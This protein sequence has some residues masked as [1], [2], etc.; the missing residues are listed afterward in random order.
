MVFNVLYDSSSTHIHQKC[1]FFEI[2]L[3]PQ[4][5]KNLKIFLKFKKKIKFIIYLTINTIMYDK[6]VLRKCIFYYIHIRQKFKANITSAMH[7]G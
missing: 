7:C 3:L 6:V 1:L 4:F 2:T 5:F